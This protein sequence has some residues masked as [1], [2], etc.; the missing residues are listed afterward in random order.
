MLKFASRLSDQD[1]A[2]CMVWWGQ[3][4]AN[5][6]GTRAEGFSLSPHLQ[7]KTPSLDL[8]VT[9]ISAYTGDATV[10]VKEDLNGGSALE[11]DEYVGAELRL[12]LPYYG[13]TSC[14]ARVG[15]AVVTGND[16]NSLSVTWT[17]DPTISAQPGATITSWTG[18]N[19]A[20]T[21]S[22]DLQNGDVVPLTGSDYYVIN[23][24][25]GSF[26]VA[27]T[28]D[29]SAV[30][31]LT[32]TG[33]VSAKIGAYVH[34]SDFREQVYSNIKVLTP[35]LPE[36]FGD[37]PAGLPE[38]NGLD[39]PA[40]ISGYK[41][42]AAF[43]DFSW[44]EGVNGFGV[45][46]TAESVGA[47]SLTDTGAFTADLMVGA[48]VRVGHSYAVVTAND[49]DSLTFAAGWVNAPGGTDPT[50]TPDYEVHVPHWT[51]SPYHSAPGFG[52]RYPQ[53][54]SQPGYLSTS[55]V[56]GGNTYNRPQGN[57]TG[58]YV[59]GTAGVQ[60]PSFGAM[61]ECA[62]RLSQTL[63]ITIYVIPLAI[64]AAGLL[65]STL[66][67][68]APS[69][70]GW[71][72]RD[73]YRDFVTGASDSCAARLKE[74]IVTIAPGALEAQGINKPLKVLAIGGVQGEAEAV[75]STGRATYGDLMSGFYGWLRN[76]IVEG[77]VSA[78]DDAVLIPYVHPEIDDIWEQA[79]VGGFP[80]PDPDLDGQVNAWIRRVAQKDPAATTFDT[81]A[82]P[83][84]SD[85]IHRN[86][87]G[88]ATL[89]FYMALAM[90]NLIETAFAADISEAPDVLEICNDALALAGQDVT[91]TSL[92][93]ETDA[94]A[95][96]AMC[97]LFWP[98][99][100]NMMLARHRFSFATRRAALTAIDSHDPDTAPSKKLFAYVL[101]ADFAEPISIL[102]PGSR[103]DFSAGGERV[104]QDFQIEVDEDGA[105]VL[106]SDQEDAELRY[107]AKVNAGM[108]FSA[109]FM[110]AAKRFLAAKLAGRLVGGETGVAAERQHTQLAEA[111]FGEAVRV[112]ANQRQVTTEHKP[113]WL[114][115]R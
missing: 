10:T 33:A 64:D 27:A 63:G 69:R 112:D 115:D 24:A 26:Q 49:A 104:T 65:R 20:Q 8:H 111:Y 31:G 34:W 28:P 29:G 88:E 68:G 48:Y 75:N 108:P 13:K 44:N 103:H 110:T 101:P 43:L 57:L 39:F 81:D 98:E 67:G 47:T 78:Y 3:S 77:N 59:G 91:I 5:P 55:P 7:P 106:Y 38:G 54:M 70:I 90:V 4:N 95:E 11:G 9:A 83:S 113:I 86:G 16:Q 73:V 15:I 76:T 17:T 105:L 85:Y 96:A 41:Q 12:I 79:T 62:W 92:D 93:P 22:N 23:R 58:S 2:Y 107:I 100:R 102:P 14:P 84:R 114:R 1:A 30:S 51:D 42:A 60:S 74:L 21:S 72:A 66:V 18:G 19:T 36:A 52:Y 35:Y 45:A 50:G 89:G 40:E 87:V 99:V 25:A 32:D 46:A 94:S 53:N 61:V 37:Y 71:W 80:A 82:F 109:L 56:T 6:K 97:R